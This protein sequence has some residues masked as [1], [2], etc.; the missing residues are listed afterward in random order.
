[1]VDDGTRVEIY[2][3]IE[4]KMGRAKGKTYK[5]TL[6]N[7]VRRRGPPEEAVEKVVDGLLNDPEVSL[8]SSSAMLGGERVVG[9]PMLSLRDDFREG[10]HGHPDPEEGTQSAEL[11]HSLRRQGK[12]EIYHRLA[13][14]LDRKGAVKAG[15]FVARLRSRGYAEEA[16]TQALETVVET[17]NLEYETQSNLIG[18][19]DQLIVDTLTEDDLDALIPPKKPPE[20]APDL[21][22]PPQ[23]LRSLATAGYET[24]K[25]LV[26]AAP[27]EVLEE[28]GL[29]REEARDA[30]REA[31]TDVDWAEPK[32]ELEEEVA[33]LVAARQDLAAEVAEGEGD[34]E[35]LEDL[36]ARE[37][38][39]Q[40]RLDRIEAW[41]EAEEE[42]E[43]ERRRV[44]QAV[45]EAQERRKE[46]AEEHA[47]TGDKLESL[48]EA[49]EAE[50]EAEERLTELQGMSVT[51]RWLEELEISREV[52]T[53]PPPTQSVDSQVAGEAVEATG[54]EPTE[55]HK[56]EVEPEGETGP[57]PA[58]WRRP[59]WWTVI[60]RGRRVFCL[61]DDQVVKT[62]KPFSWGFFLFFGFI[63]LGL[64]ALL[65][66]LYWGWRAAQ[67]PICKDSNFLIEE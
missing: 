5:A 6:I 2:D 17:T 30:L 59:R 54:S 39:A 22:L 41:F 18:S 14:M 32:D 20:S 66:L 23:V 10:R 36:Q 53:G 43:E 50:E 29:D 13:S 49:V 16:V 25:S 44:Q 51:D 42:L 12:V 27:Q 24:S 47:E 64:F 19:P 21:D 57:G 58:G 3:L 31:S 60:G 33:D 55:G 1:M 34:L 63:T 7:W 11:E 37:N 15:D 61:N 35:R 28:T 4:E 56:R 48:K 9:T 46:L 8:E 26:L 40:E 65:Y 67:C 38:A 62:E 52:Q 45:E